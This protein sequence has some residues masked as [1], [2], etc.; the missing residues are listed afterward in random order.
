MEQVVTQVNGNLDFS[1]LAEE[2]KDY[3]VTV[4]A[5]GVPL[6]NDIIRTTVNNPSGVT[7]IKA[8]NLTDGTVTPTSAPWITFSPRSNSVKIQ[9]ITG[10][11]ANNQ[12]RLTLRIIP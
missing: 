11:Q 10:L 7:A 8:S 2:L 1:N 12:Y 9:S 4:N 3:K 6:G 5:S